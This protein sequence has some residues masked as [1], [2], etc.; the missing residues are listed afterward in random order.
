MSQDKNAIELKAGD[1][2]T[3]TGTVV[4]VSDTA[5]SGPAHVRVDVPGDQ[6]GPVVSFEPR[7]LA[8]A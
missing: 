5:A 7:F 4:A 1:H 3:V 8:K 6:P 2:V